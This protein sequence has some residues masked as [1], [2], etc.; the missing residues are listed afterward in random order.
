MI[1][2]PQSL[3]GPRVPDLSSLMRTFL[4]TALLGA[5]LVGQTA[6][7]HVNDARSHGTLGDTVLSLDEAIQLVN[8]AITVSQLSA[9]EQAQI[10]GTGPIT[11]IAIDATVVPTITLE[12]LLTSLDGPPAHTSVSLESHGPTNVVLVATGRDVGLQVRTNHAHVH[13][14]TIR[15]GRVGVIAETV[16]HVHTGENLELMEVA[17]EG[18]TEVGLRVQSTSDMTPVMLMD[19]TFTSLA[20]G[21]AVDDRTTS[22]GVML[23]ARNLVF[24]DVQLGVDVFCDAYGASTMVQIYHAKMTS[25]AQFLRC[26]RTAASTQRIMMM[27]VASDLET[28]GDTVDVQGNPI[29]ETLFHHHHLNIRPGQGRRAAYFWPQDT[30]FDYHGS[31]NVIYGDIELSAGRLNRRI[32]VWNSVFRNGTITVSNTGTRPSLRWNR[33]ENCTIRAVSTNSSQLAMASSE[34]YGCTLD[35]QSAF[36]NIT[37]ENCWLDQTNTIGTVQVT[38]PAPSPWLASSSSSTETPTLGGHVDLTL[39]MPSGMAGVWHF[40]LEEPLPLLTEEPWRFYV[41]RNTLVPMPGVFVYYSTVRLQIPNVRALS[42]VNLYAQ[43]AVVPFLGQ[44]HVPMLNLPRGV[45]I[46]PRLP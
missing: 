43:P 6:T 14:L 15:G 41:Q 30:R 29:G 2:L 32:W 3:A 1:G 44:A 25:S 26:R 16:A 34:F 18:Q 33:F 27:V 40:G 22:T 21:I 42:H 45:Y 10:M 31:E 39:D 24:R 5:S 35:S 36:G 13:G 4:A 20:T 37:L 17:F 46:S 11:A 7:A 8:E 23:M 19:A 9:A 38:S 28:T 12:A